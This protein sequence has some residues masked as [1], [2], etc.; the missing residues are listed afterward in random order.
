[1]KQ[2]MNKKQKQFYLVTVDILQAVSIFCFVT[3][4]SMLWWDSTINIKWPNITFAGATF[5]AIALMVPAC[6]FFLYGFNVVNSLLRK[7]SGSERSETK[8]R[9]LK[10]T[11][12]FFLVAEFCEGAAALVTSPERLLNSLL[13]WELFHIFAFSTFI[14]LII[15]EF[16]WWIEKKGFGN[17]KQVVTAVLSSFLFLVIAI[18]LLFHDYSMSQG[19][20]GM[21]VDL[22]INSILQRAV[23]ED[24]QS[25]IIPWLSFSLTGSLIASFLDLPH[26]HKDVILKKV[27]VV[28]M[29]GTLILIAGVL[30]LGKERFVAPPVLFPAS[31]SFIFI[32][33]G[34]LILTTTGL[35]L[36]I[37][38]SSLYSRIMVKKMLLPLVLVSKISLTVYIIHNVAYI[39]PAPLMK[40]LIPS[41]TAIIAA[42]VLYSLLFVLTALIWQ[43]W[44]FKYSLEWMILKLQRAQWR[45]W[46][47][48]LS[49]T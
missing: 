16:A 30:F 33:L 46:D 49:R 41:E 5:I 31:S 36:L 44:E 12:I 1:M 9:L 2:N 7:E 43:K 39:I 19:I 21:F 11:F 37:D 45:L 38:L 13:T 27:G 4:H 35:I 10:R 28:L 6:F 15:F 23:F 17:H 22:D 26:E 47:K 3:G 24:G 42:G 34:L 14:L 40:T 8:Y 20:Q 25:P 18:F 32:A 29:G 48:K